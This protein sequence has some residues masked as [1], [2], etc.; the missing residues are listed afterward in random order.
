MKKKRIVDEENWRQA[1]L[2]DWV[3]EAIFEAMRGWISNHE[4]ELSQ[5]IIDALADRIEIKFM[6][7]LIVKPEEVEVHPD[8]PQSTE[9]TNA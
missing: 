2:V 9:N 1:A 8:N 3:K 5:L 6:P 7:R 4:D